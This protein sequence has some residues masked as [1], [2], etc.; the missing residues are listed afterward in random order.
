MKNRVF[1]Y[2]FFAVFIIVFINIK[3][4]SASCCLR[5]ELNCSNSKKP[6][7]AERFETLAYDFPEDRR[8]AMIERIIQPV[9]ERYKKISIAQR[10][11][12]TGSQTYEQ[13]FSELLPEIKD[14]YLKYLETPTNH[15]VAMILISGEGGSGKTSAALWAKNYYNEELSRLAGVKNHNPVILKMFDDYILQPSDRPAMSEEERLTIEYIHDFLGE[16]VKIDNEAKTENPL[17]KFEVDRFTND[18]MALLQGNTVYTPMYD[19]SARGRLKI[20][21]DKE[22]RVVIYNGNEKVFVDL[23]QKD[24]ALVY[25]NERASSLRVKKTS[26]DIRR[27]DGNGDIAIR[28]RGTD[29]VLLYGTGNRIIGVRLGDIERD[30]KPGRPIEMWERIDPKG[31]IIEIE[32][33]LALAN[34]EV[35]NKKNSFV[36]FIDVDFKARL[37]RILVRGR[38]EAGRNIRDLIHK[39]E[40]LRWIEERQYVMP[41]RPRENF[42]KNRIA[43]SSTR[44]ESI[45]SL[46]EHGYLE[47]PSKNILK[48]F[49]ILEIDHAKMIRELQGIYRRE[50]IERISSGRIEDHTVSST[51]FKVFFT[52]GRLVFKVPRKEFEKAFERLVYDYNEK[53]KDRLGGLLV[54]GGFIDLSENGSDE[55]VKLEVEG[56]ERYFSKVLV[57]N[58]IEPLQGR[59]RLFIDLSILAEQEGDFAKAEA[60]REQ[61]RELVRGYFRLQHN[62]WKRKVIHVDPKLMEKYGFDFYG[63]QDD[64]VTIGIDGL[65][66]DDP[67]A[68]DPAIF[69]REKVFSYDSE[70]PGWIM[71]Y[72]DQVAREMVPTKEAFI[73]DYW[74]KGERE[75]QRVPDASDWEINMKQMTYIVNKLKDAKLKFLRKLFKEINTTQTH[76]LFYWIRL[77]LDTFYMPGSYQYDVVQAIY[78]R[79]TEDPSLLS[80]LDTFSGPDYPSRLTALIKD[81]IIRTLPKDLYKNLTHSELYSIASDIGSYAIMET[82]YKDIANPVHDLDFVFLRSNFARQG[83]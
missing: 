36:F 71:D 74:G 51:S 9:V 58:R 20:G 14:M 80:R 34:K 7:L 6:S 46:N 65:I 29:H 17:K 2:L 53:F 11:I 68:Y 26:M 73:S 55:S 38:S 83:L 31:K 75:Y 23:E 66:S 52:E 42:Y 63:D 41:T 45:L 8:R 12:L 1:F 44:S 18:M 30:M 50:F 40:V 21:I 16:E 22:G 78:D 19:T 47:N 61:I 25:G 81:I 57:Q 32:G 72:Y 24:P 33:I 35:N 59:M 5:P 28:I 70:L 82:A 54:S 69:S 15:P 4:S 64:L 67:D 37:L 10:R 27:I 60:Y 3:I 76:P 56:E 13:A 43:S 77:Y 48:V 49:K 39:R 79:F 62:L